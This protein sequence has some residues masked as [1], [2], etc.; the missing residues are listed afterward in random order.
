MDEHHGSSTP[1]KATAR[2]RRQR[3]HDPVQ[4]RY[5][6]LRQLYLDDLAKNERKS[7]R[8]NIMTGE[9]YTDSLTHLD[10][11]MGYTKAGDRGVKVSQISRSMITKFENERKAAFASTG[12]INRAL[13]ALRRMFKLA[14]ENK[15]LNVAPVINAG[16]ELK[17][18]QGFLEIEDYDRSQPS[19]STFRICF[20]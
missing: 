20:K 19:P 5:A 14:I 10:P 17:P 7:L 8:R 12:T 6:D 3:C 15:M 4:L 9:A 13:A 11:F 16:A 2:T 1:L 18:R